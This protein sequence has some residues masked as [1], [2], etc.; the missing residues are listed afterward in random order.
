MFDDEGKDGGSET[1]PAGGDRAGRING[2]IDLP[3][4]ARAGGWAIDRADPAAHVTV[5]VFCGS[6]KVAEVPAT[7]YRADLEKGGIGT[8]RYGFS[9]ILDEPVVPGMGFTV[10]AFA[11]TADGVR[12]PLRPIG[13]VAL[14]DDPDRRLAQETYL[15]LQRLAAARSGTATGAD[16]PRLEAALGAIE[17]AQA[18][19]EAHLSVLPPGAPRSLPPGLKI[20]VAAALALGIGSLVIGLRSL[21]LF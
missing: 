20:A 19:I 12:A 17:T 1:R 16:T 5:E 4:P 3:H 2:V 8:G 21:A 9:A 10:T 15:V 11:R 6:R 18:R 7:A 13:A 14:D